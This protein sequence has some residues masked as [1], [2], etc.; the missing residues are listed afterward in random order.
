MRAMRGVCAMRADP[1]DGRGA[2]MGRS[3]LRAVVLAVIA[4]IFLV[5]LLWVVSASLRAPD[6]PP[7]RA[8]EWLPDPISFTAWERLFEIVPFGRYLGNSLLIVLVGVPL[9][10]L[11]ASAAGFAIAQLTAPMR[12]ALVIAS[13]TFLLVPVTA[14]WLT[15][16]L[17]YSA[18]GITDTPLVLLAPALLGGSPLFVLLYTWAFRRIPQELIDAARLEGAGAIGAWWRVGLPLV[19]PTTVA[20]A[21]L[22]FLLFWGDFISPA[23]YLRSDEWSTLTVGLRYLQQLDRNDWPVLMAGAVVL[24]IPAVL[25]FAAAQRSFLRDDRLADT[26]GGG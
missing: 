20:V 12:R 8:V 7:P 4:A 14:L 21:T 24:A 16:F 9:S 17:L 1:G 10:L 22:A 18:A 15:R 6:Q 19:V 25:L 5:P 26:F 11:I 3:A 2:R 13:V 23:L